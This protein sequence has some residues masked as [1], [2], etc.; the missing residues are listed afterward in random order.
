MVR[1]YDEILDV[2]AF[3]AAALLLAITL[4]IG[5]DVAA[6][7]LFDSPIG[8]M[9][10]FVQH[11]MLLILFLS[12]G[13][14]TRERGHV[15]VEILV[16]NVPAR[17]RR[18]MQI[19]A[20]ALSIAISA[21]LAAWAGIAAWDNHVRSVETD[22]IYPI[23]RAWLIGIIATGFFFTTVEFSRIAVRMLRDR[24]MD[25]RQTDAEL[26]ALALEARSGSERER[27][28]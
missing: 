6:R 25:L 11:S 28:S 20:T 12:I 15:A 8:W 10:E 5:I 13:W 4:G 27:L 17:S 7:Y 14:L 19:C 22:G 24:E 2:L 23:P 18:P 3:A 26:E 21:F 1:I 9:S 16:D